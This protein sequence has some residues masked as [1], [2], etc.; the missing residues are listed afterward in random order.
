MAAETDDED[1]RAS[2][3][4]DEEEKG[5]KKAKKKGGAKPR[6]VDPIVDEHG[7]LIEHRISGYFTTKKGELN[8]PK[9]IAVNLAGITFKPKNIRE[10][11]GPC[12]FMKEYTDRMEKKRGETRESVGVFDDTGE[13]L[14]FAATIGPQIKRWVN[15]S[16]RAFA[17]EMEK[18]DVEEGTKKVT[19]KFLEDDGKGGGL[20]AAKKEKDRQRAEAAK[21]AREEREG[22]E[23]NAGK[24]GRRRPTRTTTTQRRMTTLPIRRSTWSLHPSASSLRRR[25]RGS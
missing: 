2:K 5:E 24:K 7:N 8:L 18:A 23:S 21:K 19:V 4:G 13:Y 25:S 1:D 11:N 3:A 6:V 9:I 15:M 14:D 10:H 16:E 12:S 17:S 20:F 22:K